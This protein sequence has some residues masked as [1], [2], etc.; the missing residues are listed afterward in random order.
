MT[1]KFRRCILIAVACM[2]GV[3]CSELLCRENVFRNAAGHL[4]GRGRLIAIAGGKGLYEKDL[5]G[6]DVFTRSELVGEEKLHGLARSE[7]TDATRVDRELSLLRAQFG[8]ENT[9]VRSLR[10]SG[11]S[12][13]SLR[14]KIADQ[15]R[16]LQWIEKQIAVE[17][18]AT[19]QECRNFYS[20]H[21]D[22]FTQ[23]VRFRASHLFLAAP[24]ETPP[25]VVESKQKAIQALALRLSHGENWP[26]LVAEASEDEATKSRGGDL[27]FFSSTR[28]ASAF[29]AEVEKLHAGQTSKP[30]RSHLGFHIVQLTEIKAARLLGFEETRGEITLAIANGRRALIAKELAETLNRV[31]VRPD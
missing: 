1:G 24:A 7:W 11:L 26:L 15:L 8:G 28:M 6:E 14:E 17:T 27:G 4:F 21:R 12:L 3:I 31:D 5:E 2:A 25:E 18:K 29:S 13:S 19:E 10:S 9:F 30:F 16:S 20:A 23:P 22:L